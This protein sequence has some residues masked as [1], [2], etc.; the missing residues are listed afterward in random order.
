[1]SSSIALSKPIANMYFDQ[2]IFGKLLDGLGRYIEDKNDGIFFNPHLDIQ[3][4]AV[5]V[6][7]DAPSPFDRLLIQEAVPT[8][9][10]AIDS[11]L[12]VGKGQRI[13]IFAG[14][15]CG[16][17]SLLASLARGIK[18]DA[19]VLGL[20]GER[21]R[22]VGEF[23]EKEFD[24]DL[25]A[26]SILVCATSDSSAF[27]RVRAAF[28]A[29]AIA[30]SLRAQGKHVLLLIDSLTRLARAQR[31]I[32]LSIGEPPARN[33]Y[34]PSVYSLLPKLIERAGITK[35]GAI[36]A[37]YT[38]LTEQDSVVHDAIG[39]EVRSLVDGHIIL[40]RK[41]AEMGHYPAIDV[42]KSLSRVMSSVTA[43]QHQTLSNDFRH[44][45][46]RYEALELLVKLGEYKPGNDA[47]DDRAIKLYPQL[48]KFLKQNTSE[49]SS[50]NSNANANFDMTLKALANVLASH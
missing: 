41:L 32:G 16:K 47:I 27:E 38:V 48:N 13:G 5:H 26:R 7:K 24:A 31:E 11:L 9:I 3:K 42:L 10:R 20:I 29:T 17:T 30:E 28:T 46:S 22:E 1:M 18:A 6:I 49:N 45:L 19:V 36:T 21:G 33:G 40:S 35:Q 39:D 8:G 23:L 2:K 34:P 50:A 15:G 37:F 25:S 14:A 43:S 4:Q 12:T 44:M